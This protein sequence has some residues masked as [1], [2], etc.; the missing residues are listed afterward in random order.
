M[1]AK[2]ESSYLRKCSTPAINANQSDCSDLAIKLHTP[3]PSGYA[4]SAYLTQEKCSIP[5]VSNP[6]NSG[7]QLLKDVTSIS[8]DASNVSFGPVDASN[9]CGLLNLVF[10]LSD[11]R[12]GYVE[13]TV[14]TLF[15]NCSNVNFGLEIMGNESLVVTHGDENPLKDMN[16]VVTNIETDK[17]RPQVM[18]C[19]ICDEA[20]A[21][22]NNNIEVSRETAHPRIGDYF[23]SVLSM[24]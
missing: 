8:P 15:I 7:F 14:K 18:M 9:F 21:A 23:T 22:I 6:R 4:I 2:K 5:D 12:Q 13:H 11:E 17:C 24:E 3:V 19:M 16:I 1:P 10:V 20:S